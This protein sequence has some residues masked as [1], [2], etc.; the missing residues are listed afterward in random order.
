MLASA[1]F[2]SCGAWALESIFVGHI[3]IR[4]DDHAR[5][6]PLS[7]S[8]LLGISDFEIDV[9]PILE[10]LVKPA[11]KPIGPLCVVLNDGFKVIEELTVGIN[12][13]NFNVG[14]S[15][16]DKVALE[17]WDRLQLFKAGHESIERD[18][19]FNDLL[20]ERQLHFWPRRP[21]DTPPRCWL[22]KHKQSRLAGG[23]EGRGVAGTAAKAAR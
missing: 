9:V 22:P 7:F 5:R 6:Q 15:V 11:L 2:A 20:K 4:E 1:T 14:T 16:L 23:S 13:R 10:L 19:N 18:V 3:P 21:V 12:T 8:S 17:E